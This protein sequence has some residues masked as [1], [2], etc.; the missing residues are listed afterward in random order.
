MF[1]LL[2][3]IKLNITGHVS[4]TV[5]TKETCRWMA[6]TKG[7]FSVSVSQMTVVEM[8]GQLPPNSRKMM[9]WTATDRYS[10]K[11][12]HKSC[13]LKTNE[14]RAELRHFGVLQDY[15]A[16]SVAYTNEPQE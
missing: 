1:S 14:I 4:G 6:E 5:S 2:G 13:L 7:Y 10:L 16:T 8:L 3:N 12:V 9:C 11:E 15:I